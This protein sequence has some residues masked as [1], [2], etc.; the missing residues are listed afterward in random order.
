MSFRGLKKVDSFVQCN[1]FFIF[2][3]SLILFRYYYLN[4][5]LLVMKKYFYSFLILCCFIVFAGAVKAQNSF[6]ATNAYV[7]GDPLFM[8]QGHVTITNISAST[9]NVLVQRTV[10]NLVSGH[11]SYFCWFDCYG[12]SVSIS[13]DHLEIPGGSSVN[14]FRGYLDTYTLTQTSVPGISYNTYCFFDQANPGDSVCVDFVY[15][16]STGLA[17]IPTDRNYIS[18]PFPNPAVQNASFYVSTLKGSKNVS[19]K[20]F[21]TLG[22]EV[23]NVPLAESKGAVRINTSNLKPGLYFYSLWVNGKSSGSGKLMIGRN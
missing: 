6:V 10:N 1:K 2:T 15:D 23:K 20:I 21:N 12:S 8:L 9:K 17:E 16:A 3:G 5:Y 4:L 13:P 7:S 14:D 22:S 18:K 19:V 11:D